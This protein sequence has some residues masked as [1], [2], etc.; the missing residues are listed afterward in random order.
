MLVRPG[1]FDGRPLQLDHDDRFGQV[2][3]L[4]ADED[5]VACDVSD[6]DLDSVAFGD[7]LDHLFAVFFGSGVP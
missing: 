7:G 4:A 5:R 1:R 6:R 3:L 2:E